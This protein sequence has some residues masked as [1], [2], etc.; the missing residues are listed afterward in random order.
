MPTRI[1]PAEYQRCGRG[2]VEHV[3]LDC[4]VGKVV[5]EKIDITVNKLK[6][7][8]REIGVENDGY[9]FDAEW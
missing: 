8:I 9:K 4:L 5:R 1:W 7:A 6:E 3:G 2:T